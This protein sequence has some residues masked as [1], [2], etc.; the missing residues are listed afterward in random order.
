MKFAREFANHFYFCVFGECVKIDKMFKQN[1]KGL[2][3]INKNNSNCFVLLIYKTLFEFSIFFFSRDQF[4]LKH[5]VVFINY[6]S[7]VVN[8]S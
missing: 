6:A 1:C 5:H 7:A 3:R 4:V 8:L 2:S